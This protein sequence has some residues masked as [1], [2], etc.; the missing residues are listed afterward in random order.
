MINNIYYK[1]L[2]K[3]KRF[4]VKQMSFKYQILLNAIIKFEKGAL[5]QINDGDQSK[6]DVIR[7]DLFEI[8]VDKQ[9]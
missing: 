9:T 5:K 1:I 6:V 4:H 8:M 2:N 3:N 7:K